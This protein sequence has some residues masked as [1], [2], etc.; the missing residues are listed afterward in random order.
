[1]TT[2]INPRSLQ[3]EA[4]YLTNSVADLAELKERLIDNGEPPRLA[5]SLIG[6]LVDKSTG[7][8]DITAA[9]TRSR[10]RRALEA[11]GEPPEREAAP[12]I[13]DPP[14]TSSSRPVAWLASK[15]AARA[16]AKEAR[17]RAEQLAEQLDVKAA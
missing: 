6:W 1:M 2:A 15:R 3:I 17:Q 9:P 14:V 8:P 10:Y 7:R 5:A 12:I 11:L 4:H 13:L 16:Q